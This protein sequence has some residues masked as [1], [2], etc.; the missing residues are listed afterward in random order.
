MTDKCK[1]IKCGLVVRGSDKVNANARKDLLVPDPEIDRALAVIDD[2]L[3][4]ND[5]GREDEQGTAS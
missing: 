4:E 3:E 5:D 2:A 1:K